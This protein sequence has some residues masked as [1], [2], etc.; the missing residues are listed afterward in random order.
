[1]SPQTIHLSTERPAAPRGLSIRGCPM[2]ES[3]SCI[4]RPPAV[5]SP[6]TKPTSHLLDPIFEAETEK[7]LDRGY[8]V[9]SV[10]A[11]EVIL[12]R[13][14][15]LS[16]CVNVLLSLVTGLTWLAYWIPASRHPRTLRSTLSRDGDT[17]KVARQS[18]RRVTRTDAADRDL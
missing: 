2:A 7:W 9:S 12:E 8:T 18:V 1:M 10:T 4:F 3:C 14:R 16:F 13:P 17:V 6:A 11:S 15:G 5:S